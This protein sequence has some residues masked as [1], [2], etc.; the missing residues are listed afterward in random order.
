MNSRLYLFVVAA[1][2]GLL[3]ANPVLSA[4][5]CF[6]ASKTYQ[7]HR[8][9]GGGDSKDGWTVQG[10]VFAQCVHRA[11]AADKALRA[12]YPETVYG[13]SLA[14]TIGCHSPCN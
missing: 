13:L 9:H 3:S 11:E 7:I 10:N 12:H 1:S 4:D 2:L 6:A 8:L 5:S 14:A